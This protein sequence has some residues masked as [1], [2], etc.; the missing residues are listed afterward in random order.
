MISNFCETLR[1]NSLSS[2]PPYDRSRRDDYCYISVGHVDNRYGVLDGEGNE[3]IPF[4][5]D[6]ITGLSFGLLQLSSKGK[7]G[8]LHLAQ[9]D[10]GNPIYVK[11]QINCEYDVVE[12]ACEG[13]ILLIKYGMPNELFY[14]RSVTVYLPGPSLLSEEYSRIEILSKEYGRGMLSLRRNQRES[15][16]SMETGK[17][18]IGESEVFTIGGMTQKMP[19]FFNRNTRG[20]ADCFT[21]GRIVSKSFPSAE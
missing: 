19:P 8:L 9:N 5:Y 10:K 3:L 16:V 2:M 1:I 7:L 12:R 6:N 13:A 20:A 17:E 14:G 18:I 11:K 21:L 15:I 4:E